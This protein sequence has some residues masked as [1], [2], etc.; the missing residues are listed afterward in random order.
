MKSRMLARTCA[1]VLA[2]LALLAGGTASAARQQD[3]L[4]FADNALTQLV[5]DQTGVLLTAVLSYDYRELDQNLQLAKDKS[6]EQYVRQHTELINK[7]RSNATKQKQIVETKVVG[8]GM[9]ELHTES[10]KLLVFL[11]QITTRGDISKVS[12]TGF[13]A[14]VDMKLID[15]LWKLDNFTTVGT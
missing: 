14:L 8:I 7:T 9:R 4:A 2:A 11:D 12:T 15:K 5:I 3:N 13:T 1:I 10:A 6:T